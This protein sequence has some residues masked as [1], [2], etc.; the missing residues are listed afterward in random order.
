[1]YR[2]IL[3]QATLNCTT[4]VMYYVY[5]VHVIRFLPS[6][7]SSYNYM[8]L[9]LYL[10]INFILFIS[11]SYSIINQ[12]EYCLGIIGIILK[13]G[14][15]SIATE[16]QILLHVL[17]TFSLFAACHGQFIYQPNKISACS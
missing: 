1:M 14:Y 12:I 9:F 15:Y 2:V 17:M 7:I 3:L 10:W 4:H 16:P 8:L 13:T 6:I 11:V 5:I